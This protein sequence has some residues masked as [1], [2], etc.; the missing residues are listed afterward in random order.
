ASTARSS[1]SLL[2]ALP[3]CGRHARPAAAQ[4]ALVSVRQQ[5]VSRLAGGGVDARDERARSAAVELP[6]Q[7]AERLT[8]AIHQR[9]L[10]RAHL[11]LD[12][13]STRL[14]TSQVKKW[15]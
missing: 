14:N 2:G 3:T 4:A 8:Q 7:C 5:R 10:V 15:Y 13:K 6:G 12:Q 9:R 11:G 1:P